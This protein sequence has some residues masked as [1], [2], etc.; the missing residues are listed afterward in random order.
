M[1]RLYHILINFN[2]ENTVFF[3]F[4]LKYIGTLS[5]VLYTTVG[6][7]TFIVYGV[8]K[9]TEDMSRAWRVRFFFPKIIDHFI[10]V[11][12]WVIILVLVVLMG[13]HLAQLWNRY[14]KEMKTS[15]SDAQNL[16]TK[17]SSYVSYFSYI[18]KSMIFVNE[19]IR[20]KVFGQYFFS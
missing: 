9:L 18:S 3:S 10:F 2:D 14:I 8:V 12:A 17:L 1:R 7:M 4:P 20:L 15:I 16:V 13:C 19:N 5:G 11:Q 6:V